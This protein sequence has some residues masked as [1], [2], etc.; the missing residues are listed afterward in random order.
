VFFTI[1]GDDSN[2]FYPPDPVEVLAIHNIVIPPLPSLQVNVPSDYLTVTVLSNITEPIVLA[3]RAY[4]LPITFQPTYLL[5]TPVKN[6]AKFRM[7]GTEVAH[8]LGNNFN[9]TEPEKESDADDTATSTIYFQYKAASLDDDDEDDWITISPTDY[10]GN[11][12][13]VSVIP[14]NFAVTYSHLT[15]GAAGSVTIT[16]SPP[17]RSNV[18]LTPVGNNLN[19][20]PSTATFTPS[21]SSV[22]LQV[23]AVHADYAVSDNIPFEVEYIISGLNIDDYIPPA[24]SFLAVARGGAASADNLVLGAGAHVAPT[25]ALVAFLAVALALFL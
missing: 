5:F 14:G 23:S 6:T 4:G 15:I 18:L 25:V 24:N 3:A 17:P 13:A 9:P 16:V 1:T 8:N 21:I 22:T 2:L 12:W 19:F 7:I 11:S 20:F 10:G